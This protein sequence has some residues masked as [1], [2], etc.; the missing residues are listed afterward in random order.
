MS[1]NTL[2]LVHD[3]FTKF[4]MQYTG[5]ARQL[6]GDMLD[7]RVKRLA[8]EG[9]ELLDAKTLSGRVD[10]LVDILYIAVGTKYLMGIH[11]S[12]PISDFTHGGPEDYTEEDSMRGLAKMCIDGDY[13]FDD[14]VPNLDKVIFL[15]IRTCYYLGLPIESLFLEVHNANMRKERGTQKTSKYGNSFDIVKPAGWVGPDIDSVLITHGFDPK[16]EVTL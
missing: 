7:L 3:F 6:E 10:A 4:G 2:L 11:T 16:K 5:E 13:R 12:C 14:V 9:Q 15:C 8:E 1:T